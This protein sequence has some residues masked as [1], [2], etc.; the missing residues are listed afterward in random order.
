MKTAVTN[1][2]LKQVIRSQN[3]ILTTDEKPSKHL[4]EA[5]RQARKERKSG[6]SSPVFDNTEEATKWLEI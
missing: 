1:S 2:N 3:V 5:I 4:K 6:K